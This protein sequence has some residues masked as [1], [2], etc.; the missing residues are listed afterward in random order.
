M[1]AESKPVVVVSKCLGFAAC[2]Y[3]GVTIP[4]EVV[5][6]LAPWVRFVPVCPEVEIGLGVPREPIRV[7]QNGE[8]RRLLQP[9]TGADV[10]ERMLSFVTTFLDSLGEVHGFVL[11]GR[12]PSC[13]IKD[14]KI[15]P[16]AD[17]PIPVG[18][19]SGFFGAAVVARYGFLPVEDEGRLSNF[20]IREHFLTH[21]FA[22]A[23]FGQVKA[24]GK[25]NAL[26]DFHTRQ[27]LLLMGYSQKH[28]REMGRIVANRDG[29]PTAQLLREYE[30]QLHGALARPARR[31]AMINVLMHALGY[32]SQQL[33]SKEKA[34]FLDTLTQ[35]QEG[36]VPLSVPVAVIKSWI[37]RFG[38]PYL[39]SQYFF[40]PY[41]EP[42]VEISDSGK[43]R[44]W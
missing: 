12:S 2:R 11:K 7:V 21:L 39:E 19:G 15:F 27:K 24:N 8:E 18:K 35:F 5:E 14:V 1:N 28:L 3:N 34:F 16:A 33:G 17:N 20:R 23:R 4:S 43:G 38:Q 31:T 36:R 29:K 40:K 37:A 13:G 25:M 42:L 30:E 26:V 10:T 41:P 6:R 44:D 32:F 22:T 9:A